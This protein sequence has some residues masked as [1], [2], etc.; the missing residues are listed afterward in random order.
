MKGGEMCWC[1]KVEWKKGERKWRM[2]VWR[3]HKL[4]T[5]PAHDKA[6]SKINGYQSKMMVS[7][8]LHY[9]NCFAFWATLKA[10]KITKFYMIL[11]KG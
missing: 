3:H 5:L 8:L 4:K 10:T 2:M 9:G 1:D 7:F 11:L 6:L